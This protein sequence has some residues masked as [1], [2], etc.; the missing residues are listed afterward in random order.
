[1]LIFS[2]NLDSDFSKVHL[3]NSRNACVF[4]VSFIDQIKAIT[5]DTAAEQ[6]DLLPTILALLG[7]DP[8]GGRIVRLTGGQPG[9]GT[10][11][12]RHQVED[13]PC[14]QGQADGAG[15]A[16][17]GQIDN[18][19]ANAGIR[20][21]ARDA[22]TTGPGCIL[23]IDLA[24]GGVQY[25]SVGCA[26]GGAQ[27]HDVHIARE[28]LGETAGAGPCR[29]LV[30]GERWDPLSAA[31]L[32]ALMIR[33]MDYNDIYW[34]QDPSHPSDLIPA[35]IASIIGYCVYSMVTGP[36][37]LAGGALGLL[38]DHPCVVWWEET[39]GARRRLEPGRQVLPGPLGRGA[40]RVAVLV[41]SD[42]CAH[43]DDRPVGVLALDGDGCGL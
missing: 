24:A 32:N 4:E 10:H 11:A 25:D 20:I 31:L 28:V 14:D 15:L 42:R 18:Q 2:F 3:P 33:V 7:I 29:V 40:L 8:A 19:V 35:A 13:S 9:Q 5:D 41:L 22:A 39:P 12:E 26:L 34:K 36:E 21:S 1:M 43:G 16:G 30:T 23:T 17:G 27:Q 6:I 37:P 38:V